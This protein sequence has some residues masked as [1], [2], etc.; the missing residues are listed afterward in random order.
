MRHTSEMRGDGF[1]AD[2]L[3]G[4]S[5]ASYQIEGSTKA[6]GRGPSIWDEFCREPGRVLGGQNGDLACDSYRRWPE[7]IALLRAL[8]VGAYRFSIAWPRI[9]PE[10]AG[11]PL[12]AGIDWYARLA[13]ALLAAGIEPWATLYHWDLPLA[14]ERKGGWPERDT[15]LRFAEYADIMFRALG[16]RV[17]RW[18]T[19]NEPWCSAFLGY[20]TGEHAPGRRDEGA[21]YRAAHHLLLGHGLAVA[22]FRAS[23]AQGEIGIVIN[24]ETPRPATLRDEDIAAAERASV[25]RTGLWLDPIHGRGYP[26]EHLCLHG[27]SMPVLAGDLAA[28]A[29]PI[30]FVGINYYNEDAVEAAPIGPATREGHVRV[31]TWQPKTEMGWDVEPRGLFRVLSRIATSW[32]VRA[33]YV[34]ENG[35]AYRDEPDASGAVRD[36]DRIA[37]Y[38]GHIAACRDALAHS[39]PLRGYFAW[40]LMDNFE[41]AWGY[42]RKFGLVRVDE[43]TGERK[44]KASFYYYRDVVAGQGL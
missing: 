30:D 10:G 41:W 21:A 39:V 27:V 13:D 24:P 43:R 34:T 14:L 12:Q 2:F 20:A 40:T 28:I 29:L 5:T 6:D 11:K 7:D 18:V 9:Q 35:A 26:D 16:G 4:C 1:P 23:G 44:P 22:A 8:G 36:F 17:K 15:A 32:P 37:Y 42:S 19:L 31:P 3:W 33:L 25:Q 38:R